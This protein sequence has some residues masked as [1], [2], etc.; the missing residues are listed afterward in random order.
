MDSAVALERS[1]ATWNRIVVSAWPTLAGVPVPLV[2]RAAALVGADDQDVDRLVL[3]EAA[4]RSGTAD[5]GDLEVA[6]QVVVVEVPGD[7]P[8][9]QHERQGS[10]G[11]DQDLLAPSAAALARPSAAPASAGRDVTAARSGNRRGGGGTGGRA[12]LGA[13]GA[14]LPGRLRSGLLQSQFVVTGAGVEHPLVCGV[15]LVGPSTALRIH[16]LLESSVGASR[17]AS[18]WAPGQRS[19]CWRAA[20][21]LAGHRVAHLIRTASPQTML[22]MN[23]TFLQRGNR[24]NKLGPVTGFWDCFTGSPR[25]PRWFR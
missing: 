22:V 3:L 11:D 19:G 23:S 16:G 14:P 13:G 25:R 12:R 1:F 15:D 5:V 2:A 18:P 9:D 8:G 6:V 7:R 21:V 4:A 24:L 10:A 20:S 17:R